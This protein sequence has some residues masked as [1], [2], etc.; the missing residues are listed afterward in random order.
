MYALKVKA[1]GTQYV[2]IGRESIINEVRVVYNVTTKQEAPDDGEDQIH[3]TV[4]GNEDANKASHHLTNSQV[5]HL[6]NHQDE[7]RAMR[8]PKRKGPIPE[9]SYFGASSEYLCQERFKLTFD[10]KVNSVNP[11]KTPIVMSLSGKLEQCRERS[12]VR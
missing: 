5:R 10:W 7:P 1:D 8:V 9:K 2:L 11:R 6:R 4:E 3:S 12:H